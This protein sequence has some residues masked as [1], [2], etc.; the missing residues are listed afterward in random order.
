MTVFVDTS[1][2]LAL[3]NDTDKRHEQAKRIWR[4]LVEQEQELM[5]TNYVLL[6]TISLVQRR[7]GMSIVRSFQANIVEFLDI[8]WVNEQLHREAVTYFLT[9][10]RRRLS[11]VDCISFVAMRQVNLQTA[12]VFDNHFAEQGF[13]VLE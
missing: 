2:F 8:L 5:T 9:A 3:L 11:L 6:E 4:R 12:F 1:A 10:N 7:L 13:T